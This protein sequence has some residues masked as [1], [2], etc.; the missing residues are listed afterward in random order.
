MGNIVESTDEPDQWAEK[1]IQRLSNHAKPAHSSKKNRS[2]LDEQITNYMLAE[3][4]TMEDFDIEKY[5][6]QGAYGKVMKVRHKKTKKLFA[7]KMLEKNYVRKHGQI[8]NTFTERGVMAKLNHPFI[9]SLQ[10][11]FQSSTKLFFVMDYCAGG[12]FFGYLRRR[13][14]FNERETRFYGGEI[15]LA[16]NCLH[17]NK[18]V[19]RDLK[20]ENILLDQ[21]GH[22]KMTDFGLSKNLNEKNAMKTFCGST[23]YLAPEVISQ[24]TREKGYTRAVDWWSFGV[25][26]Y[27]MLTG[28]PAF[29]DK[30]TQKNFKK[31]LYA[32]LPMKKNFSRSCRSLLLDLLER[33]P[34]LRIKSFSQ[35]RIH[36]F[37]DKIDWGALYKKRVE[38]P[39]KPTWELEAE[40]PIEEVLDV[41]EVDDVLEADDMQQNNKDFT[42]FSFF[43]DNGPNTLEM[44]S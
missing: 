38:V 22:I 18:I 20:P 14:R 2:A 35:V 5:I 37:F 42:N 28:L 31:I 29:Y 10:Y 9:V 36:S 21:S 7:M 8:M 39:L 30:N 16:L 26:M 12:D 19:Y 33:D 17:K 44:Y 13:R 27:E 41:K 4:V 3:K 34:S 40:G 23:T 43:R 11:A 1:E 6:G 32:N 25:M 15:A 24:K